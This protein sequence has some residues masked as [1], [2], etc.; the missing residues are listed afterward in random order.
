MKLS[1][2]EDIV[3]GQKAFMPSGFEAVLT[4][5]DNGVN[6]Q[7]NDGVDTVT[8]HYT[9]DQFKDIIA[10]G[11]E[12]IVNESLKE[13]SLESFEDVDP[14]TDVAVLDLPVTLAKTIPVDDEGQVIDDA[15]YVELSYSTDSSTTTE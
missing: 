1:K 7:Y 5:T 14:S 8:D 6:V 4:K 10:Q 9:N 13:E 2:I 11:V 12:L 15:Y 3:S